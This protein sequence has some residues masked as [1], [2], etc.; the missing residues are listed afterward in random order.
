MLLMMVVAV[1]VGHGGEIEI[2]KTIIVVLAL[3][4]LLWFGEWKNEVAAKLELSI[5]MMVEAA[6]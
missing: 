5:S 3:L 1:M 4:E 2:D 6:M